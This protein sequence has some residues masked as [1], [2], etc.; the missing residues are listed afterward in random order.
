MKT[1]KIEYDRRMNKNKVLKIEIRLRKYIKTLQIIFADRAVIKDP[2]RNVI[3]PFLITLS[4]L[5][6]IDDNDV[7]NDG[8]SC[9][10]LGYKEQCKP[11]FQHSLFQLKCLF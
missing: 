4:S 5:I 2:G 9:L 11:D 3:F 8:Q 1:P 7:T 6:S 10:I